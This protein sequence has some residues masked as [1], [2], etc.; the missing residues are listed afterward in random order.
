MMRRH[1]PELRRLQADGFYLFG[2]PRFLRFSAVNMVG[3]RV[4]FSRFEPAYVRPRDYVR[5]L[6]RCGYTS[7]LPIPLRA[8][9]TAE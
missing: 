5:S 7:I 8:A 6:R 2:V 9:R 1:N 4:R 3:V